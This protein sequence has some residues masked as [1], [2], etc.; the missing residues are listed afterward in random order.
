MGWLYLHVGNKISAEN[1]GEILYKIIA[2]K[3]NQSAFSKDNLFRRHTHPGWEPVI[4]PSTRKV[5]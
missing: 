1:H 4:P 3:N 5:T 2:T